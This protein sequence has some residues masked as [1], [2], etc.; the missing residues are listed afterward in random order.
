MVNGTAINQECDL[1]IVIVKI[2]SENFKK[3]IHSKRQ[4][5]RYLQYFLSKVKT[6]EERETL[7]KSKHRFG[8]QELWKFVRSDV[9]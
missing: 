3:F 8:L 1:I 2:E 9:S 4:K 6:G 7:T 5:R